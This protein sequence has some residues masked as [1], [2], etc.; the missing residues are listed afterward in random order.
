MMLNVLDRI[1]PSQSAP[2][3]HSFSLSEYLTDAAQIHHERASFDHAFYRKAVREV[4]RLRIASV[5]FL[6]RH[7]RLDYPQAVQYIHYMEADGIIRRTA[8]RACDSRQ[9]WRYE[10]L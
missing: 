10:V 8:H 5:S 2:D 4:R 1:D 6:R 9:G 3:E 7:F